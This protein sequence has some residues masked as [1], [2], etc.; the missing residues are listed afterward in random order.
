MKYYLIFLLRGRVVYVMP[1]DDQEASV[2]S[3][4]YYTSQHYGLVEDK[5][6]DQLQLH[7]QLA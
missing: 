2:E 6:F 4:R 3:Y 1:F 5:I 7:S